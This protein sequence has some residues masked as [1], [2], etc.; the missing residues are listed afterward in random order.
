RSWQ[1][2]KTRF[3]HTLAGTT[4]TISIHEHL[5]GWCGLGALRAT[6]GGALPQRWQQA[7]NA[8]PERRGKGGSMKP[9][10]TKSSFL[11][12]P[13]SLEISPTT[14][15]SHFPTAPNLV[16]GGKRKTR[17]ARAA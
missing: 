12:L 10:K 4:V 16:G 14:Q 11:R 17:A 5:A 7:K 9:A 8:P 3:R 6:R 15:D 1:I 13:H 2:D